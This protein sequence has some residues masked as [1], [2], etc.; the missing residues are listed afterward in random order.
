RPLSDADDS[1]AIGESAAIVSPVTIG[2][3]A[4]VILLPVTRHT[5]SDDQ[6]RAVLAHE[7]AHVRRRDPF[8]NLL[9][10]INRCLFWFHPG[11]WW[12]ERTLAAEAER[13]CDEAAVRAVGAAGAYAQLL[14]ETARAIKDRGGRIAWR[15][16]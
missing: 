5:W 4:P 3:I 2:A 1:I 6:W 9:A 11:A 7:M 12:L 14:V 15:G 10:Q 13:A 16:V 8:V